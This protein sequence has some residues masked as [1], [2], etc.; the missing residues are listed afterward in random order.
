MT[1]CACNNLLKITAKNISSLIS[2]TGEEREIRMYEGSMPDRQLLSCSVHKHTYSHSPWFTSLG[3]DFTGTLG[4]PSFSILNSFAKFCASGKSKRLVPKR[5]ELKNSVKTLFILENGDFA[6]VLYHNP[7]QSVV[8]Q[9]PFMNP[10]DCYL[11]E[12]LFDYPKDSGK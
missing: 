1:E 10:D 8:K 4:M 12:W 2:F 3:A 5:T 7:K 9:L 11:C 6:E